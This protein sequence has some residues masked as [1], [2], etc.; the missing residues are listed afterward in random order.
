MPLRAVAERLYHL[1]GAFDARRGD[2]AAHHG[3]RQ[4]QLPG[5]EQQIVVLN[6][7][8]L[9]RLHLQQVVHLD[10]EQLHHVFHRECRSPW[11]ITSSSTRRRPFGVASMV[12]L[13]LNG[14]LIPLSR[15]A[16]LPQAD[17]S[18]SVEIRSFSTFER[19]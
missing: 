18:S 16:L 5:L 19:P 9:T 10:V 3:R 4:Q 8:A 11:R 6:R 2:L 13:T 7:D 12:A 17:C 15:D 14:T 1:R